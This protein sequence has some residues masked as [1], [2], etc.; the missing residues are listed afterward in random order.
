MYVLAKFAV[1]FLK[2]PAYQRKGDMH[3]DYSQRI[4]GLII[5]QIRTEQGLS[6]EVL[7]GLSGIARSHLAM[8]ES[9]RKNA[10]VDTL[11]RITAALNMR[12][13]ELFRMTEDEIARQ[14]N[15]PSRR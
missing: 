15:I 12:L 7:S 6:Q 14:H 5:G 2:A 10:S 9:G 1:P 4:T 11:W 8:I 3:M 13:S